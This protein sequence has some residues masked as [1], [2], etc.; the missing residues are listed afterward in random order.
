M[1]VNL[2][3]GSSLSPALNA[4]A[5]PGAML[6]DFLLGAADFYLTAQ[7]TNFPKRAK[8][9]AKTVEQVKPIFSHSTS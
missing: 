9:I 7:K 3:V 6:L 1:T 4:A 2:Y 5:T 8:W